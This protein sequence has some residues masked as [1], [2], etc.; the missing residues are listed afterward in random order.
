MKVANGLMT[1]C[2]TLI[3]NEKDSKVSSVADSLAVLLCTMQTPP[4]NLLEEIADLEL[5][6]RFIM[7]SLK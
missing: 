4:Q 1:L 6:K 5:W 3:E 7:S 2:C